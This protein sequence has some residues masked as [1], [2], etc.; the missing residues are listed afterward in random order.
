MTEERIEELHMEAELTPVTAVRDG[1]IPMV[2]LA[3]V[4]V[5]VSLE[6]DEDGGPVLVVDVDPGEAVEELLDA[7]GNVPVRLNLHGRQVWERTA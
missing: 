7:D 4:Y 2:R 5:G 1:Q 6:A 3:G